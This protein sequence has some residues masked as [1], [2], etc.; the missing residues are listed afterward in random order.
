MHTA[1]GK[2]KREDIAQG[3]LLYY[4]GIPALKCLQYN[5]SL[6]ISNH[7]LHAENTI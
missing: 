6:V 7:S 1:G 2:K 4:I 3:S 5:L